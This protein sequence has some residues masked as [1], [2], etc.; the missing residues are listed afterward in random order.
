MKKNTLFRDILT[1]ILLIASL[2]LGD[3][4]IRS[5]NSNEIITEKISLSLKENQN[6]VDSISALCKDN[7]IN[8]NENFKDCL[9]LLSN[10]R[11]IASYIFK[12]DSL[13]FWNSD[14]ND[15]NSLLENIHSTKNIFEHGNKVF[16]IVCSEID[17]YKIFTSTLLYHKKNNDENNTFIL[18]K[19]NGA[20]KIDFY[21][22]ENE[23]KF[24]LDYTPKMNDF[25]SYIIGF[26]I[27]FTLIITFSSTYKSL[28]KLRKDKNNTF[29]FFITSSILFVLAII[30]Q[31]KLFV[32]SSNLFSQP[33]FI[34]DSENSF[35]LGLLAEFV[36]FLFSNIIVLTSNIRNESKINTNIK[37]IISSTI[38]A[39]I[40]L[41]YT[42]LIYELISKT[43][44]PF[45][46]LQIY[47]TT[48]ESY[49]FLMIICIL[50]CS[51]IILL[52]NL[53]KIFV[54]EK[55]SYLKSIIAIILVGAILELFLT[56]LIDFHFS[57]I[58]NIITILLYL[59]LIWERKSNFRIKKVIRNIGIIT[60]I[61][62]QLTY[63]LYLINETK[64]R[65]EMEWFAN[66]IGDESDEAF[67]DAIIEITERIKNDKSLTEWQKNNDFPSDDSILNY[68]NTKYFNT[69]EIEGYNKVVTLCDTTT[70][71]V[72]SDLN[73]HEINCNE[74]FNDILEYNYTKKISE[75]LTL[76]DD[77]TTDSYYI[78][79]LDLSPID[80]NYLNICYIEFY[81]EY[82][83][84]FIGI[85]EIITS[86]KN[87][88]M[89]NL[90]NYSFSCYNEN[91]LQ[92]K[93]GHY[94]YPNELSSFRYKDEEYVKT[95][96]FK[97]LTKLFD[98]DKTIIVTVEKPRFIDTIAPFSYIFIVLSLIY[99]INIRIFKKEELINIRQSFHAK[100]QLTIILTLGFAFLVAGFTSFAFIRNSL[101]RKTTEFQYEK[102]KSIVKNIEYDINKKDINNS[103]YLK[104]YKENYFTD[105][106]I[107]D[108]NGFL[109]NTTQSKLFE[110]F[111]S[112]II[113]KEAYENIQLRK[114]FYYSCTEEIEG[115]EYNSSY[116]PLLDENGNIHSIINIPFF[117]NK[118]SN[119]SNISNF[120]ITYLNI[121]LVVM[122]ISVLIVIL[123]TRKTLQ[124]LEMIQDKMQKI[125]LGGKNEAIE[126]KSKDEIGDLIEIYNKLIKELEISANKLMRSERETAWRE[127]ARQVAH[128]IKNPL[129]PMK[130]NIQ[131]LQMA[132]DEKN[133]DIDRKLRETT[134]SILE[135]IDILSNIAT[136]FS[137]YAKLP[138]KNIE[139][140]N[141]KE[142]IV[143][144]IN[145]YNNNDNIKIDIIEENESD[146]V[147]NSDKNNL[148]IVFGN[149]LKNAIQAIGKKENGRIEFRITDN[150]GR[151]RI[152]ISD[153]GCGIGE[154]EKK[155]IFMPNFTTKSSGMG[156][157]LSIVYDILETLGGNITF[158]SEVGKGTT[159]IVEIQGLRD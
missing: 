9:H 137:D 84:N 20:Y 99:F 135:Q 116:F 91:I 147:I 81:K 101:N 149:I 51:F 113:N 159:F 65:N 97:H 23:I 61:S 79:K 125:N 129:T 107:Y 64:E 49:F 114:R 7:F 118:M 57:I 95:K 93:F 119:N 145:L 4:I 5:R 82:I 100:M 44:I 25:N 53:M 92:Y 55:Q 131:F 2:I 112:K 42:Y 58:T 111:K 43:D 150:G 29:L 134:K 14:I 142:V 39:S 126:W 16:Y 83:L 155:K 36:I 37:I 69:E 13:I 157:G 120:I 34:Y 151:Y 52:Q 77:P 45:S 143:N 110:E 104:K 67:E 41:I 32:S 18:K 30:L 152:E 11:N 38:L 10:N 33:C 154:E 17:S 28:K 130:L 60:L 85:P 46:F 74:L 141:L 124:P 144:T 133:P 146:Y 128:E 106:N 123:M 87:V 56:K 109:V 136:A 94:N 108:T 70:I 115:I 54:T 47:N 3:Y 139:T 86:Y 72:V 90:V 50:S 98:G 122:G 88:L 19:I 148:S 15:P 76:V 138:K 35:S 96:I 105:I 8:A 40:I 78:L 121:F 80:T 89:P 102:N 63:I 1:L 156:V 48:F 158:E 127:M 140:F 31:R 73:N 6:K 71:L 132:W 26:L 22:E 24:N 117:D 59:I 68:F 21:I 12:N 27:F 103:E 62:T 153:N 75:E 66:V